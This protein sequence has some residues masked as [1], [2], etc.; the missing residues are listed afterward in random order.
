MAQIHENPDGESPDGE[1]LEKVT[2]KPGHVIKQ[3][4]KPKKTIKAD[5]GMGEWEVVG[6]REK[7]IVEKPI[8]S[9]DSDSY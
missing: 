7:V 4:L 9:D 1:G 6:K 3:V 2:A 5:D 8:N